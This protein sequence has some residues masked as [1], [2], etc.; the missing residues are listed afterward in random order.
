MTEWVNYGEKKEECTDTMIVS[1]C[2]QPQT[3]NENE[4]ESISSIVFFFGGTNSTLH[5]TKQPHAMRIY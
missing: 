3:V 1:V 2:K 4:F 5:N